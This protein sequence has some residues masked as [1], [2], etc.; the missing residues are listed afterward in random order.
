MRSN[1]KE[2]INALKKYTIEGR[3]SWALLSQVDQQHFCNFCN[4]SDFARE[5]QPT[6]APK[7]QFS[8][9]FSH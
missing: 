1:Y 3:G 7:M 9:Q 8:H 6:L 5:K 2:N 4:F